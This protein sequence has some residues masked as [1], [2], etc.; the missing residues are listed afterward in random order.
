MDVKDVAGLRTLLEQYREEYP[1][2]AHVLADGYQLIADC[3]EHPGAEIR[4]AAQ[5]YFP[6]FVATFVATVSRRSSA[7][8][9]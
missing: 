8:V 6:V 7:R 1:E 9:P 2:D 5:R 4:A 3:L